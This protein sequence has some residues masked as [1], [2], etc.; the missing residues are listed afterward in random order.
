[1]S[2]MVLTDSETLILHP[3]YL[4]QHNKP[5][6]TRIP[7]IKPKAGS[8]RKKSFFSQRLPSE[9][10]QL[11]IHKLAAEVS[12]YISPVTVALLK[13]RNIKKLRR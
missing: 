13:G 9:K 7:T 5:Q 4:Q 12:P 10:A 8:Q 2:Q 3:E 1:M 6:P 11:L